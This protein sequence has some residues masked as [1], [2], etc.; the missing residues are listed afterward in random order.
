MDQQG[1]VIL[2]RRIRTE[3][4]EFLRV[5]GELE[6]EPMSVAF[7]ATFG[8]GWFAEL[9]KDAGIAAHM[10]HPRDT[11]AIPNARVK[12]DAVDA[13]TLA[14]GHTNSYEVNGRP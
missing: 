14:E 1:E 7:E 6:P 12:N 11:K 8:W 10:A 4:L 13:K 5:F 9:L 3:P 2:T